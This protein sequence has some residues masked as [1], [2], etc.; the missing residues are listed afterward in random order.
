MVSEGPEFRKTWAPNEAEA[1]ESELRVGGTR[2]IS[3]LS[4]GTLAIAQRS[5]GRVWFHHRAL[6]PLE[7]GK[8]KSDREESGLGSIWRG[9][10]KL[11]KWWRQLW[12]RWFGMCS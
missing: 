11:E 7:D 10:Q 3:S 8:N 5:F 9:G 2:A 12:A 6:K 4:K 1:C